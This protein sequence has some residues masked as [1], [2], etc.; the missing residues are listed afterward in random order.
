MQY[1]VFT[2][3]YSDIKDKQDPVH[4]FLQFDRDLIF[5]QLSHLEVLTSSHI[6]VH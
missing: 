1:S 3:E 5:I 2:L 4:A 6:H